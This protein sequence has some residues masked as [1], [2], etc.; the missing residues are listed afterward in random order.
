MMP[1]PAPVQ[2]GYGSGLEKGTLGQV[3]DFIQAGKMGRA[4]QAY[5][6]GGGTWSQGAQQH[7]KNK[8]GG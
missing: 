2:G 6:A 4:K 8:Y 5:E 3:R 1:P 7:L